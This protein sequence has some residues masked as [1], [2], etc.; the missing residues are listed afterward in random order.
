LTVPQVRT[1]DAQVDGLG[2]DALNGG[3]LSIDRFVFI[4]VAVKRV[5]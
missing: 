2:V 5:A 1:L 4:A 3:A